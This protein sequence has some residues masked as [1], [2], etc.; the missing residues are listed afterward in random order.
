MC[1]ARFACDE[2]IP[3]PSMAG[4]SC[5]FC[6]PNETFHHLKAAGGRIR[7]RCQPGLAVASFKISTKVPADKLSV[8]S[9]PTIIVAPRGGSREPI[10]PLCRSQEAAARDV[11]DVLA[12]RH[13]H[14]PGGGPSRQIRGYC[15]RRAG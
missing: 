12:R 13:V 10:G 4:E 1:E 11:V 3:G 9:D 8:R 2:R 5:T 7:R 14:D 15:L 6:R